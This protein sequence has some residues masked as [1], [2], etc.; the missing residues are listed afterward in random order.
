MNLKMPEIWVPKFKII[1]KELAPSSLGLAGEY[2]IRKYKADGRLVEEVG[3]FSNLITNAG[4]ERLGTAGATSYVFVGTG[5]SA[6]DVTDTLM[7]V[8]KAYTGLGSWVP[9]A[10]RGGA[11]DYWTMGSTTARFAAGVAA[12]VL[13]EVGVGWTATNPVNSTNH[14]IFSRALIVDGND[15]PV[16]ITVLADE[17]L[18]VT[19]SLR[20]YPPLGTASQSVN[21]SGTSY[22]FETQI[23]NA[24]G[25]FTDAEGAFG[26]DGSYAG[27][28]AYSGTAPGT[29]PSLPAYTSATPFVNGGTNGALGMSPNVYDP[30]SL[31][32]S[33]II[34]A[35]LAQANLTYGIRGISYRFG[36]AFSSFVNYA[37]TIA[38]AIPKNGTRVLSFGVSVGWGRR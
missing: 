10:A 37:T 12:G 33:A 19:Y 25:H 36:K 28:F 1:E 23:W 21:I 8:Y 32:A 22:T 18:D 2:T 3:P 30:G 24:N 11:P 16:A 17:Y 15:A 6:P 20:M 35:S 29:A 31:K 4:L 26:F 34:S 27:L 9:N 7:G 5:T 13:T 38:P 14:R